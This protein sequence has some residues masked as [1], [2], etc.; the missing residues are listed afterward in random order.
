MPWPFWVVEV[1]APPGPAIE[2]ALTE[3]VPA[4]LDEALVPPGVTDPDC[5]WKPEPLGAAPANWNEEGVRAAG[6]GV[7]VVG[8]QVRAGDC[9]VQGRPAGI[10][11]DVA[12][13]LDFH[14]CATHR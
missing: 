4:M 2:V 3:P 12:H 6:L 10:N 1:V 7:N 9:L 5:C 8:A 13:A 11:W 14:A